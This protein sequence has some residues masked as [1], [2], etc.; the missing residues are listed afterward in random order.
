MES[1]DCNKF[2]EADVEPELSESEE[3]EEELLDEDP[4]DDVSITLG[5]L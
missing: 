3:L 5:G 4:D 2:S 1:C